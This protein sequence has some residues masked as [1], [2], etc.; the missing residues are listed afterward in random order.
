L[1]AARYT[2]SPAEFEK[3]MAALA[4]AQPDGKSRRARNLYRN[5]LARLRIA[6]TSAR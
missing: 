2:N 5:N 4:E 1:S 3:G 6:A